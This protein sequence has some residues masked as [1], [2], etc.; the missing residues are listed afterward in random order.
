MSLFDKLRMLAR[1]AKH[2]PERWLPEQ[3]Q[4]MST[5]A[6]FEQL[7]AFQIVEDEGSFRAD[8]QQHAS[9]DSLSETWWQRHPCMALGF[10]E[11]FPWMAAD[12]LW[13]RLAPEIIRTEKVNRLMQ[14]GY[15]VWEAGETSQACDLWL[16][17]WKFIQTRLLPEMTRTGDF[18]RLFPGTQFLYNW[19][20]DLE[21]AL[22]GA[23]QEDPLY[24]RKRVQYCQEWLAQFREEEDLL[25]GNFRKAEAET[26]WML[27][28]WEVAEQKYQELTEIFPHFAWGYISWAEVYWRPHPRPDAPRSY[29]KAEGILRRALANPDLDY[30]EEVQEQWALMSGEGDPESGAPLLENLDSRSSR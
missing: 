6:I 10:D 13:E 24:G 26:L 9:A 3:V 8:A 25:Q 19:C 7:A 22:E 17:T 5:E 27:G 20:Q 18:D 12:V 14:E 23:G 28:E 11:D 16:R 4:Q 21:V 1:R 30:P 15:E 2:R 29:A